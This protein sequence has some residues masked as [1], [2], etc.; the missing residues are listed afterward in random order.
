MATNVKAST[1]ASASASPSASA[2]TLL[3]DRFERGSDASGTSA[4]ATIG[5]GP[6]ARTSLV[7]ANAYGESHYQGP[8]ANAG[9]I[10]TLKGGTEEVQDDSFEGESSNITFNAQANLMFVLPAGQARNVDAGISPMGAGGR[11]RNRNTAINLHVV[12]VAV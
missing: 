9:I 10:I 7:L 6:F 4:Q 12:A 2:S 5:V 8:T 3:L 11:A 1:P